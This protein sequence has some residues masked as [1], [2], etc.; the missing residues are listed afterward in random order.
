[1]LDTSALEARAAAAI[2]ETESEESAS[3]AKAQRVD[4]AQG[5]TTG[6]QELSSA[7]RSPPTVLPRAITPPPREAAPVSPCTERLPS[8]RQLTGQLS[9]LAEAAASQE[10]RARAYST[11]SQSPRLRYH[12]SYPGSTQ[13]SP[14]RPYDPARSPTHHGSPP[15]HHP[16]A[17]YADRRTSVMVEPPPML[18]ASSS[19]E[20]RGYGSSID[21]YSTSTAQTTP[22]EQP[23]VA[24]QRPILPPPHGMPASAV[25]LH[26]GFRCEHSGCDS[27]F[28]TQYLLSSHRNVHSS[29]RPHY[30][31]VQD[32][33]RGEGGK[34]FKRKNEMIRHGLVRCS[35]H[36]LP[37]RGLSLMHA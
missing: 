20:S 4:S 37:H 14:V 23:P 32:C 9:E 7:S 26:T 36:L 3:G 22:I 18:S 19:C 21:G 33:V 31:P 15:R 5:G 8:F 16:T 10:P 11:T 27:E 28:P 25:I 6:I 24:T 1:M 13:T 35:Q 29:S 2:A 17:Y 30:C 12:H 34:G